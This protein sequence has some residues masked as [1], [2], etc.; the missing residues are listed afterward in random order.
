MDIRCRFDVEC[1]QYETA[2]SERG[3]G[4]RELSLVFGLW[5]FG[6]GSL[7][8]GLWVLALGFWGSSP[9]VKEG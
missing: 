5:V 1:V 3:E 2:K 8:F 9:T 7:V 4:M 6:L